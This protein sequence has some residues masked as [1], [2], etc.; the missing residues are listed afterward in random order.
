MIVRDRDTHAVSSSC[1]AE[2]YHYHKCGRHGHF[3]K[4]CRSSAMSMNTVDDSDTNSNK[5]NTVE[6]NPLKSA[7]NRYSF[8]KC[9]V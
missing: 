6:V 2:G 9:N 5:F 3:A 4:M 8:V 7:K 1:P